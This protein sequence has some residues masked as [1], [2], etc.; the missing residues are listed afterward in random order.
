MAISDLQPELFARFSQVLKHDKLH[1]AFLFSGGFGAMEMAIWLAQSR[2]CLEQKDGLPCGQC[3]ECRLV[4]ANDFTDLH[5]VKPDGQTIK[6]QQIRDLLLTF[7]QSGFETNRQVV[8][9]DG[10]EKLHVNAANALLKSIEEPESE[11]YIFLLTASENM[12]LE[13]IKSRAQVITF[14]NQSEFIQQFLEQT[15][16]L[17]TDATII[18]EIVTSLTDAEEL[19]GD[20]A[21]LESI[22][23]LEKFTKALASNVNIDEAMLQIIQL[24]PLFKDKKMQGLAFNILAILFVKNRQP[25]WAQNVFTAQKYWRANVNFQASLEKIILG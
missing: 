11:I 22:R 13:T 3:R 18:S 12:V 19:A 10:A 20:K 25:Q 7:S 5:I 21:F 1:H 9:I 14:P 17:K 24:A 15:G 8:V 23:Q 2:F 6:T 4:A 16:T